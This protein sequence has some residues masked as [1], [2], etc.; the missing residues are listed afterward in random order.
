MCGRVGR[1]QSSNT[2]M[3]NPMPTLLIL[4]SKRFISRLRSHT[5]LPRA[6]ARAQDRIQG[7]ATM[8]IVTLY[9]ETHTRMNRVFAGPNGKPGSSNE[10]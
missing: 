9:Q 4:R 3:A 10:N 6:H 2:C 5:T 8:L 1:R 7:E